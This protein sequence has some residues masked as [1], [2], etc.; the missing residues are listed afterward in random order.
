MI[1]INNNVY[2]NVNAD[3]GKSLFADDGAIWKQGWN[4]DFV[5]SC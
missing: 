3:I 2:Y 1:M 4:M 5:V